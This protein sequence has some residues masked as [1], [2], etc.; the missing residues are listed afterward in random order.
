MAKLSAP[1]TCLTA[2]GLGIVYVALQA[3]V[4][5]HRLST[6]IMF[7]NASAEGKAEDKALTAKMRAGG[8]MQEYVPLGLVIMLLLET[9][10]PVPQKAVAAYGAALAL[11]RLIAAYGIANNFTPGS[12]ARLLRKYGFLGTFGT[13]FAAGAYL[14]FHAVKT[15]HK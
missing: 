7:G 13:I 2:G 3:R 12:N 4:G 15:L 5:L 1:L 8:N 10:T 6:G 11:S 14:T 9:A